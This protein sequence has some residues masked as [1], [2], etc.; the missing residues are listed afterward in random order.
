[1]STGIDYAVCTAC[2]WEWPTLGSEVAQCPE[3]LSDEV[4]YFTDWPDPRF[5][6]LPQTA[7]EP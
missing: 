1:M 5:S 3:C 6:A 2:E 7:E 4:N